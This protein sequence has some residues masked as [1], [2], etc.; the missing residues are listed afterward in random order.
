MLRFKKQVQMKVSLYFAHKIAR[1]ERKAVLK[2]DGKHLTAC[3][4][5]A[6]DAVS[7]QIDT[8]SI[9]YLHLKVL[10]MYHAFFSMQL[11]VSASSAQSAV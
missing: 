5:K 3:P 8:A 4:S 6:I 9:I 7:H 11:I 10:P 1:E 2:I